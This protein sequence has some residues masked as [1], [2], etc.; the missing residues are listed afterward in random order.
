MS[1]IGLSM[2]AITIIRPNLRFALLMLSRYC[3]NL[4]SIHI[5]V[6]TCV[7]RY[8]KETLYYNIYYNRNKSLINYTN[9][10]FVKAINNCRLIDE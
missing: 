3:S 4:D 7:L 6:V 1:I 5:Y 2:Y 8:I 10:D 9:V